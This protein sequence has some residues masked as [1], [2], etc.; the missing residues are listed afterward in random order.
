MTGMPDGD[1]VLGHLG[2]LIAAL[3][4]RTSAQITALL[5]L[6]ESGDPQGEAQ[7][8]LWRNMDVLLALRRQEM[9]VREMLIESGRKTP[10]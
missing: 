7:E 6:A 10:R 8:A 2:R 9:Q 1:G 5:A 3:E 4:M